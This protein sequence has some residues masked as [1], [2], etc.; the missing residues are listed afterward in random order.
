MSP[1]FERFRFSFFEDPNSARDGLDIPAL[2]ALQGEERDRAED[3]LLRCLPDTRGVIG[4][5]V[6]RSRRAEPALTAL[7]AADRRGGYTFVAKALWQIR[8][9]PRWLDSMI[10]V[11]TEA[12]TPVLRQMAAESLYDVRDPRAGHAL[13]AALDDA[14]SLVRYHAARDLLALHGLPHDAMDRHHM[15]YRVMSDDTERRTGGKRD[16]LAA[17]A[18]RP[19]LSK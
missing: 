8:P 5:G 9:D 13:I 12:E 18:G 3:L 1:A 2:T 14:A 4:L 7:L 16:I 6:L 10:A 19:L 11:L 15:M 17:I